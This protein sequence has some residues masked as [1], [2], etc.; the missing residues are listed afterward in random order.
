[1]VVNNQLYFLMWRGILILLLLV[2]VADFLLS[3]VPGSLSNYFE[4]HI[5]AMVAGG[6]I[7]ILAG[8]RVNYF[9]YEDE[10]EIIHIE[11]K[12]LLFASFESPAQTRYEF[13]KRI[14]YDFKY[15]KSLFHKKLVIYLITAS[16]VKR[17]RKFNLTFVPVKKLNYV[18]NSLGK[19]KAH[20]LST[21]NQ[22]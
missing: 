17:V 16:G 15:E 11:S 1:M 20:N 18:L 12:S 2:I 13:P 21:P 22:L 8:I 10:Y 4:D 6:C 3:M 9:S 19:I 5:P 14:I 7:L